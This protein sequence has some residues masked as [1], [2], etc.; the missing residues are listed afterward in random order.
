[1]GDQ[2]TNGP[3]RLRARWLNAVRRLLGSGPARPLRMI[4]RPLRPVAAGLGLV[5]ALPKSEGPL[6]A[7]WTADDILAWFGRTEVIDDP[8]RAAMEARRLI[9]DPSMREAPVF[10]A[11]GDM[12]LSRNHVSTAVEVYLKA[13]A[14]DPDACYSFGQTLFDFLGKPSTSSDDLIAIST[15]AASPKAIAPDLAKRLLN[16]L[17]RARVDDTPQGRSAISAVAA[18]CHHGH[19]LDIGNSALAGGAHGLA[20]RAYHLAL[21]HD[22]HDVL[23]RLQM[24]VTEFLAGRYADAERHFAAMEAV[25]LLE[26]HRWG[27]AGLPVTYMHDT[28]VQAIG[29]I[30]SLDT[31]VKS[32]ELGWLPKQRSILAIDSRKPPIGWPL[33]KYWARHIEVVAAPDD[34]AEVVDAR[35]WGDNATMGRRERDSRR[36]SLLSSFWCGPD[37]EGRTRW[38]APLGS[39]VQHAWKAAG[40]APLL[41]VPEEERIRFRI[42]MEQAFGLPRDA[43]F[44]LIHVREAGYKQHWETAHAYTRNADIDTYDAAIRHIVERG[45][46]V[47]RG[48]DPSMRA[49]APRANVI[50]YAV[51]DF[52]TPEADILL[53]AECLFFLGTNSGFS[54]VPPLFGRPC[55]LTNWS[56]L[57]T[58]NW[59]PGD[60]FI[61]KL[62]R[63]RSNGE[64]IPFAEM[65][66]SAAGWSQFQRD[67]AG[68]YEKLDNSA[69]DLLA[70]TVE[71]FDQIEGRLDL[72]QRDQE[73]QARFI[74]ITRAGGGYPGSRLAR[75]FAERYET[76]L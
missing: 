44:V 68:E 10:L 29:H 25:R 54:L 20:M 21:H 66:G 63:R 53:C 3:Q 4:L 71:M 42:L 28:W 2:E 52:R 73:R 74:D 72:G 75:H 8:S 56:P 57:G 41:S 37:G 16:L 17:L 38:Y 36:A 43:W 11:V 50:D 33:L 18:A 22:P 30:A 76:L 19:L 60:L 14:L 27:V 67:F 59:Y 39:A 61:P 7:T 35:I 49:I 62:V 55:A 32:M 58:P 6:P 69:E 31:Y 23:T 45:G 24:G 5:Y 12:L 47:V 9:D 48:G 15:I 64:L 51:S 46:W 34:P 1:V 26:Q 70:A 40:R 13:Q 65:Y